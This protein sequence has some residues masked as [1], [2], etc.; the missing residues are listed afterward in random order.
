MTE[1]QAIQQPTV[2]TT[3]P[4][5]TVRSMFAGLEVDNRLL[6]LV[7]ALVILWLAFNM[8]SGGLFLTP[9]NLWNLSVQSAAVAIMT[10]GMVLIIVSRNIDLSIG[11]SLVFIVMVMGLLQAEWIPNLLGAGFDRTFLWIIV[12]LA[13]LAVGAVIGSIQGFLVAYIG[14]PS[15][16]VTLGGLLIWRGAAFQLARGRTIAPLD[17][18]FQLLGGGPR[19]SLG[20]TAS[21]V[22][23]GIAIAAIVY[24][25][26]AS[27]RRRQ[28]YGFQLRPRWADITL[29]V[30]GILA[31][32]AAVWVAN[33]YPWPSALAAQYA[34]DNGIPVPPGGLIIP[35]GIA[36]PVLI[37]IG[38]VV[39]MHVLATRRPF[40][41][42]VYAIG[43]NPEAAVLAGINTRLTIVKT[44]IAMGMLAAVA[45]AIISA[46]LNA[47]TIAIGTGIELQVIAAA[48]IG[49]T[50]LSGGIGT[51]TGGVLG[52]VIMQSLSSGMVLIGV[53]TASQDIVVGLVLVGAVGADQLL[54]RRA[55]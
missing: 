32:V 22:V 11:S 24:G 13:G 47:A 27:R 39:V 17:S 28:R 9:R 44:F 50:S 25:L 6:G 33:A 52:A 16:I 30:V 48:V 23:G 2:A 42:H 15:F 31:I 35:T 4:K 8:L 26:V 34:A 40:G 51:I 7:A 18:T 29:G 54:R 12:V 19:G 3:P 45:A 36:I 10:T 20:E 43:G 1:A 21:W 53:D 49:G 55:T 5:R 37:A 46:R 14:I 38:V 41:R